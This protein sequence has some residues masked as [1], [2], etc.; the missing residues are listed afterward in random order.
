MAETQATQ[1]QPATRQPGSV[2]K[3]LNT[4]AAP[5]HP[6]SGVP[7]A[8]NG[9]T[10]QRGSEPQRFTL[11]RRVPITRTVFQLQEGIPTIV[12]I[13]SQPHEGKKIESSRNAAPFLCFAT[14]FTEDKGTLTERAEGTL[15]IAKVV[16]NELKE[17]F[18]EN[19]DG[20][21]GKFIEVTKGKKPEGK[22]F[23]NYNVNLLEIG[24]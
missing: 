11:Q 21:V 12:R 16:E 4:Q 3:K 2:E 18:G 13:D 24:G 20:I 6:S 10:L 5:I 7:I 23:Y 14:L 15:I 1:P 17:K 8:P 22:K 9:Q 19:L